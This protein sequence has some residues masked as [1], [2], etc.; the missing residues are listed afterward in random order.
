MKGYYHFKEIKQLTIGQSLDGE[1]TPMF[2][3]VLE[4]SALPAAS[5]DVE[6]DGARHLYVFGDFGKLHAYLPTPNEDDKAAYRTVMSD[7]LKF[8]TY[9]EQPA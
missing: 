6:S 1:R 7:H 5:A 2:N 8:K 9:K 4:P 3:V